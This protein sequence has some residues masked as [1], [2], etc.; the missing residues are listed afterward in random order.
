MHSPL[1]FVL[2]MALLILEVNMLNRYP[3]I[4]SYAI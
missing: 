3:V 1:L 2:P 4:V